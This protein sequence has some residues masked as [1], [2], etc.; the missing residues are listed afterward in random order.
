MKAK[1]DL[2]ADLGEGLGDDVSILALVTSVS[3]ATG[4][5]AGGGEALAHI[6]GAAVAAGVSIGAHPSYRDREGFGRSSHLPRLT[7]D[8]TAR[9]EFVADLSDQILAVA[10][11]VAR[12][13]V[14]L[15]H[16]KPHGALYNDAV[17]DAVAASIVVSAVDRAGES[18]GHALAIYTQPGG[19][20]VEAAVRAGL[21]VVSEG[22]ADRA[23]DV[24]GRLVPRGRPDS[25]LATPKDMA[26]QA[27]SLGAGRVVAVTGHTVDVTVDSL[28]I[29]GDTPGAL[30]G[31]RAVREALLEA[32]WTIAPPEGSSPG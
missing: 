26:N 23:Y 11:A 8:L 22:F 9:R 18:L 19:R 32:G 2:N 29:H 7:A 20:L 13:G 28:C 17:V 14:P 16:V 3:L 31:A 30:A 15:R 1:I 6:A 10:M 24:A 25:V 27:V 12:F 4:A 5:H 21:S